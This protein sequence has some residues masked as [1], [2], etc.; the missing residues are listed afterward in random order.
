M[1]L[2]RD[3]NS[4]YYS[5]LDTYNKKVPGAIQRSMQANGGNG[6]FI[7]PNYA[8][9]GYNT[10]AKY[11]ENCNEYYGFEQAYGGPE[12]NTQFVNRPCY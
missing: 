7:V 1:T 5:N 4:C 3:R 8:A 12:C 9:P 6:L 10:L 2:V 11:P